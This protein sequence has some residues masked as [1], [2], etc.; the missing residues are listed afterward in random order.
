V[1]KEVHELVGWAR[2]EAQRLEYVRATKD[3]FDVSR[4][5]LAA[6]TEFLRLHAGT[7]SQFFVAADHAAQQAYV[8]G[9]AES[10]AKILNAWATF[11]DLGLAEQPLVQ[12]AKFEASNDL[13]EQVQSLLDDG[14]VHP[15]A[16]VV[17]AGAALEEVLRGLLLTT[18]AVVKGKPG[19]NSYAAALREA[20]VLDAQDVK[21]VT[22]W[23]GLRNAA[24][25][26]EFTKIELANA[27]LMTQGINLFIRQKA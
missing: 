13:M 11:V 25:H 4:G 15:A 6:A 18:S 24:A 10:I 3:G 9:A 19:I 23:A 2:A 17:L 8:G 16:P 20:G 7:T 5:E 27:R 1:V 21:D 14:A 22:S 26:G 12:R